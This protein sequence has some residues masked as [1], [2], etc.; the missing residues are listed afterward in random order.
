MQESAGPLHGET[1]ICFGC[2]ALRRKL[3]RLEEWEPR[4]RVSS[5]ETAEHIETLL[6][7]GWRRIEMP[8]RRACRRPSS[9]R[10]SGGVPTLEETTAERILGLTVESEIPID[11]RAIHIY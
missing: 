2:K 3:A 10:R 8:G 7:A 4:V 11:A 6:G 1:C 5:D 9:R